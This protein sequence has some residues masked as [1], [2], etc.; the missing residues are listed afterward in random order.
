MGRL[1]TLVC[2]V[3]ALGVATPSGT[4]AQ[5]RAEPAG[6]R[7]SA[8]LVDIVDL[9]PAKF[10]EAFGGISG[11]DY[12]RR[13]RRW[14]FLS[15]DRSDQGPARFY[16]ARITRRDGRWQFRGGRAV[17]LR[18]ER[19]MPFPKAGAGREAVDPEA[20]RVTPDRRHVIWASEGDA[21]DGFGPAVRYGN[22][23]GKTVG[24]VTLPANLRFDS[25]GRHGTR[26]NGS[27][28]GLTFTPDGALWLAMEQPLIEDGPPPDDR[29]GALVRFTRLTKGAPTQQFAYSLDAVPAAARGIR[30]DNG[31]TEILAV[32][33]R[34]MLVLER[35][36]A[37]QADGRY[38][39]HCRLYLADFTL[40][41]DIAARVDLSGTVTT[42]R[43]RLIF[44]FDTLAH[45]PG[46]LE[47]MAWWPSVHGGHIL[48]ANDNN[49]V[50]DEPT[51]LILMSLAPDAL[52]GR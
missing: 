11:I 39:F 35:S 13:T 28:E 47:A 1:G 17:T 36:G 16:T 20:V 8:Q 45:S 7:R 21:K 29:Q 37:R 18:D 48:L 10:G 49:F 15:D 44:D 24:L 23:Q 2:A 32:D 4:A 40:A 34:N 3:V 26:D 25:K 27:L 38:R 6:S 5:T 33:D 50:A 41:S 51:R 43:K 9:D 19:G 22:R 52:H 46:N 30:A 12:D 31:V 14:I 42:A